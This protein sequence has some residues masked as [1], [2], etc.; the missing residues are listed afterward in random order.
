MT[1]RPPSGLFQRLR[2][3]WRRFRCPHKRTFAIYPRDIRLKKDGKVVGNKTFGYKLEC[4]MEC[5]K[6]FGEKWVN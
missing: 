4:C 5:G 2:F 6:T 1:N 3:L